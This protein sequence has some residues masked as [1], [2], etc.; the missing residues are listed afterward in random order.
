MQYERLAERYRDQHIKDAKTYLKQ[1]VGAEEYT[2]KYKQCLD[3]AKH[4]EAVVSR[5]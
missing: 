5:F 4:D 3:L 2:T 1:Q